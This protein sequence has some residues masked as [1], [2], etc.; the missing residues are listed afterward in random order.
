MTQHS[1]SQPHPGSADGPPRFDCPAGTVI[2][3]RDGDLIRATG[4]RYAGAARFE[5]PCPE[6]PAAE[7][8]LAITPAP[9]CPQPPDPITQRIVGPYRAG[10]AYDE[11]CQRLSVTLPA[12]LGPDERLPVMVWIHGG[13]YTNGVADTPAYDPAALVREQR[14]IVVA[15][16]YRLGLFGYLGHADRP[17]NLGLYDQIEA[18]RWIQRNI[19]SFGGDPGSVTLF[20]ESAGGDAVAHLMIA[21]GTR[22]LFRRA[23]IQSAPLGVWRGREAMTR[24]M[25]R[26][27][28]SLDL[29]LDAEQV[30]AALPEVAA[31]AAPHGLKAAMAFSVQYG[32]EPLPPE[33]EVY[34]AWTEAAR[35]IDVLIGRTSREAAFYVDSL[36]PFAKLVRIPFAGRLLRPVLVSLLTW[37]VFGR[38]MTRLVRRMKRGGGRI[39]RY[40]VTWGARDNPL[41]AAHAAD[42]PL[43]F[44]HREAWTGAALLGGL[45]MDQVERDGRPVRALWAEF[46]R[47]GTLPDTTVPGVITVRRA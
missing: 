37:L 40:T 18:L 1:L 10:V 30:L 25:A 22:G 13:A 26:A 32:H 45:P 34:Q 42:V 12:D 39:H 23:I 7:P 8:V 41:R 36:P 46:A 47:T 2:A 27:A 43:L 6:P 21:D 17:A 16:T 19:E 29:T 5:R 24:D 31:Q 35:D 44:P 14:V 3:R 20:G 11:H 9:A 15:V 33:S 38:G 28:E 4:I